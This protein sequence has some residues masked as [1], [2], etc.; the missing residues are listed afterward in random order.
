MRDKVDFRSKAIAVLSSLDT[1]SLLKAL[2]ANG[3]NM[4][5]PTGD[6]D[7]LNGLQAPDD[8]NNKI[9]GWNERTIKVKGVDNRPS[10]VDKEY[11]QPEERADQDM[12]KM[13]ETPY[14]QGGYDAGLDQ[15][16]QG[17]GTPFGR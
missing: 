9:E 1:D 5:K 8:D 6:A 7:T 13:S 12:V 15:Y 2:S 10:L 16:S 11:L 17:A 3:I 4:G 14:M